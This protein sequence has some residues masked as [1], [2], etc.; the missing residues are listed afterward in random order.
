MVQ[1]ILE[2]CLLRREK[3]MRDRDGKLIVDLPPKTVSSYFVLVPRLLFALH[4]VDSTL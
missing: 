1:Y 3:T 2:S 4:V